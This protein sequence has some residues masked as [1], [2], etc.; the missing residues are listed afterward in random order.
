M[1]NGWKFILSH[2]LTWLRNLMWLS[3]YHSHIKTHSIF[4]I[5]LEPFL[6]IKFWKFKFCLRFILVLFCSWINVDSLVSLTRRVPF[7]FASFYLWIRTRYICGEVWGCA[8]LPLW[9]NALKHIMNWWRSLHTTSRIRFDSL[10]LVHMLTLC[11]AL[12]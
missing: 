12:V 11:F 7:V 9:T 4:L 6:S 3:S 1:A 8:T 2:K 5:K 10:S